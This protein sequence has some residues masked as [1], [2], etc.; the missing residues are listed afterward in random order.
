MLPGHSGTH[1][2]LCV[3]SVHITAASDLGLDGLDFG[4]EWILKG[5][6]IADAVSTHFELVSID[7]TLNQVGQQGEMD[8]GMARFQNI[9]FQQVHITECSLT[10]LTTPMVR[11]Y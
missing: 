1:Y 11:M 5:L 4:S 3:S 2:L 7:D 8:G 6:D 9:G 10:H